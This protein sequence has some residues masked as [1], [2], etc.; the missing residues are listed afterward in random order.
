MLDL[1]HSD[2]CHN[3]VNKNSGKQRQHPRE[4]T[5]IHS[6]E[7]DQPQGMENRETK[8]CTYRQNLQENSTR[9]YRT[10]TPG[11]DSRKLTQ[12]SIINKESRNITTPTVI[13]QRHPTVEY[14]VNISALKGRNFKL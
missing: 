5:H 3:T 8:K 12:L 7:Q 10:K 14:P 4:D 9:H 13:R 6:V 2:S 11:G 1:K